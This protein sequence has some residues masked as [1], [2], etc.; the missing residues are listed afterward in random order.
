MIATLEA[1]SVAYLSL[2]A[3][4][5]QTHQ[6]YVVAA[7]SVE[8][9][10]VLA[11]GLLSRYSHTRSPRPSL[12]IVVYLCITILLNLATART[13][14]LMKNAAAVSILY[15]VTLAVK[16][17][18]LV[19]ESLEKH[20]LLIHPSDYGPE[21]LA[22]P[23]S[24]T[25]FIW[26]LSLFRAGYAAL[27][28]IPQLLPLS[29]DMKSLQLSKKLVSIDQQTKKQSLFSQLVTRFSQACLLPIIPR[30]CLLAFTLAQP[31]LIYTSVDYISTTR[32]ER[33]EDAG[34]LMIFAYLL[35]FIGYSV[36]HAS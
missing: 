21:E 20:R 26:V 22:G 33:N 11:V 7:A 28:T 9:V 15:T 2:I 32:A 36:G 6:A 14:W 23:L 24:R 25:F 18:C 34:K 13:L 35:S 5:R 8:C 27:L 31:F 10:A 12:A 16:M 30:V 4:N 1:L 19:F 3:A 29:A 17:V